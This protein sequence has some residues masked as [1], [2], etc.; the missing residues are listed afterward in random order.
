MGAFG[1][2]LPTIR[3][4]INQDLLQKRWSREK[5]LALVVKLMEEN[6]H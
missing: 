4:R 1:I 5:V 6:T 2:A 3:E